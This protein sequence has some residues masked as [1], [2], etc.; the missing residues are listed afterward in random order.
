M[1][2]LFQLQVTNF[3][4]ERI[5]YPISPREIFATYGPLWLTPEFSLGADDIKEDPL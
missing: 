3:A 4:I 5:F 2:V 1:P